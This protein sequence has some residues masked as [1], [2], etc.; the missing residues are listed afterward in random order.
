MYDKDFIERV[1]NLTC[2][3][4]DIF[5]GLATINYDYKYPFN[6]YYNVNSIIRALKKYTNKEWDK[7]V[8]CRWAEQYKFI[9]MG[10]LHKKRVENSTLFLCYYLIKIYS[11][12]SFLIFN[13]NSSYL[14]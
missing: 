3:M 10:G 4:D 8:L 5:R 12:L 7:K 13:I 9:L 14:C 6:K 11:S 1:S 2:S